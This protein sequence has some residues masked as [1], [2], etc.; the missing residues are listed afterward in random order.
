MGAR[1][2]DRRLEGWPQAFLVTLALVVSAPIASAQPAPVVNSGGLVNAASFLRADISSGAIAQGSIF[3]LFG[4]DLS[5][6]TFDAVSFPLPR[7][8]NSVRVEVVA[9]GVVYE[10][11]LLHVDPL[12]IN[13]VFPSD[14]PIGPASVRVVRDGQTS[15]AEPVKVVRTFPGVFL[16]GPFQHEQGTYSNHR[17]EAAAQGYAS[18]DAQQLTQARPSE[19]GGIITLW[20]TGLF[21]T[22]GID[23]APVAFAARPFS[24]VRVIVGGQEAE[25]LYQGPSFCCV[26][27]DQLNIRLPLNVA[28]GCFV[29]VQLVGGGLPSNMAT[30]PIAQAG[31][32]CSGRESYPFRVSLTRLWRD[33]V[34]ADSA[35][36]GAGRSFRDPNELPPV[37]SCQA[38]SEQQN[39][40]SAW[41]I[42]EFEK[43]EVQG[44]NSTFTLS[45]TAA[46]GELG[47][48]LYTV[49]SEGSGLPDFEGTIEVQSSTTWTN[50]E[51]LDA[52][53][54]QNGLRFEWEG[55]D[56]HLAGSSQSTP[57]IISINRSLVCSVD[58]AVG[59]FTVGPEILAFLHGPVDVA[60]GTIMSAPLVPETDGPS[61]GNFVYT[62][63]VSQTY[64]L[65]PVRLPSI[66]VYLPNTEIVHAEI[67]TTAAEH[68]RGLMN[69]PSLSPDSGMLF[70]F[71]SPGFHSF[72]MSQ[73]LIPLDI[74]W[75]DFNRKIVT[76]SADT[77]PCP[78]DTA[79][80]F[81]GPAAPAMYVLELGAGEAERR[82]LKV[83]DQL[84]W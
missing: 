20:A 45:Q 11:P 22:P 64:D 76:I 4:S 56:F 26:G 32:S 33:G 54:R 42:V 61:T 27:V 55:L 67:A 60:F 50:R 35:S 41:G 77:P 68:Q 70:F 38:Y 48:G 73:T 47:P 21:S 80:P 43:I 7:A 84:S 36:V 83:N 3:S 71:A 81:Y 44:P 10:A 2:K 28:L 65:G 79:C 5:A 46:A 6:T 30:I 37:G 15:N 74:I 16:T 78:P 82:G 17:Q 18:G 52:Y 53:P 1:G 23:D 62:E 39:W 49:V 40:V 75:I 31:Q 57:G 9:A 34:P 69:R 72:W 19:P 51:A 14:V 12:Q 8:V 66:P 63:L 13:G 58:L 24:P 29:P 25:I 59:A